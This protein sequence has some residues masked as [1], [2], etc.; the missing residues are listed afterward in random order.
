MRGAQTL[1]LRHGDPSAQSSAR[2]LADVD[3]AVHDAGVALK[4]IDLFAVAAGP[5]SFT[6]L[7]AGIATVK[8]FAATLGRLT[9]GVP[10]LHAVA[11]AST[12]N[13]A[14]SHVIAA[15]P[16]GRGELFAQ[17]FSV[18][19]GR[20]IELDAPTHVAPEVLLDRAVRLGTRIDWTGDGAHKIVGL[21]R[22]RAASESITVCEADAGSSTAAV[23]DHRMATCDARASLGRERR[24]TGP[25]C[26]RRRTRDACRGFTSYLCSTFGCGVE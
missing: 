14:T 24:N 10:T 3:A 5:G 9:V 13:S 18:H 19:E 25:R 23:D 26:F 4:Q 22:E 20:I 15:I 8:S 16:A 2:I 21:I 17:V 6:G 7:R 1:A 12:G 11:H